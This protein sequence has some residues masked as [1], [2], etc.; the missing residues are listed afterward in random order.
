VPRLTVTI[1]AQDEERDLPDCLASGSFADEIILVDSGSRDR[2]RDIARAA[3]AKVFENPWPGDAPQ[4]GFALERAT[5]DWVLNL[6]ADE[7]C[8]PELRSA[9]PA[10][11][12]RDD[13]DGYQVRFQTW[14][15]GRRARFGGLQGE[16]HLRLFR[17]SKASYET[18]KVHGGA[19]VDGRIAK[20]DAPIQHLTYH[21]LSAYVDK[22]NR[23]TTQ[24]SLDRLESGRRFTPLAALRLPWGFFRRYVIRLGVLD[25][26]I[27]FVLAALGG[28]YDF[29]KY[30]KIDDH[31]RERARSASA[32][33]PPKAASAG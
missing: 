14:L 27:G 8:S 17:R 4:K 12:A 16:R 22:V 13:V 23:Y 1:I 31:V 28:M 33:E 7:R 25:G 29:L 19:L 32:A 9:L 18:K 11:M 24:R 3:G 30:A 21:S 26:Y 6:D 5:G 2:T 20:L 15:L 10:A